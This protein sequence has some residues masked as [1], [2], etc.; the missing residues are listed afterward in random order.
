MTGVHLPPGLTPGNIPDAQL[1]RPA[2]TIDRLN[3]L[4]PTPEVTQGDVQT[5][6]GGAL[7][8]RQ[9]DAVTTGAGNAGTAGQTTSTRETL[10]F[11]ARAILDVMDSVESGPMRGNAPLL[12]AAPTAANAGQATAAMSGNLAALVGRSG[13]FYES[14]LA[15]WVAGTL[16]LAALLEEPQAP[17]RPSGQPGQPGQPGAQGQTPSAAQAYANNQG[18]VQL[19]PY[20]GPATPQ[21]AQPNAAA[22]LAELTR[23]SVFPP[24]GA[25]AGA[26]IPADGAR[27]D[28]VAAEVLRAS[29]RNG[30]APG[31]DNG[32][33]MSPAA[34]ERRA[35]Q[36]NA[37]AQAYQTTA[38]V[39]HD[40]YHIARAQREAAIANWNTPDPVRTPA[41]VPPPVHPGAE[42]VV[43]QQLELLATQQFR[44]AVEAWPGLPVDWEVTRHAPREQDSGGPD[45]NG[46]WSTRVRLELPNLGQVDAVLTLGA[47]GLEA[48]LVA[49]DAATAARLMQGRADFRG[50]LDARGIPLLNLSVDTTPHDVP[51]DPSVIALGGPA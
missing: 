34:G 49:D 48:R 11:A 38:E 17:L 43:R 22:T 18:A 31:A 2:L 37:A 23:P 45:A 44:F 20:G 28:A 6:T 33:P 1:S 27:H 32:Q 12:P 42:G 3:A 50:Q 40:G 26:P 9:P 16:P 47:S 29:H 51:E 30:Q 7:P 25:H 36:A 4:M 35:A 46:R 39:S 41:D 10:S 24:A 19:L 13:L 8:A 14:H 15:Q 21:Q 5:A